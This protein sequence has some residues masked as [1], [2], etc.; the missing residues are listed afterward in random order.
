MNSLLQ[1]LVTALPVLQTF[2]KTDFLAGLGTF[3]MAC[4]VYAFALGIYVD[5]YILFALSMLAFSLRS[6]FV[7]HYKLQEKCKT[8]EEVKQENTDVPPTIDV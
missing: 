3:I 5:S 1:L 6:F 8:P 4:A 7:G 2:L